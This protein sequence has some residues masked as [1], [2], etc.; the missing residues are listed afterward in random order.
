VC[1]ADLEEHI[2]QINDA[3]KV[4]SSW[5]FNAKVIGVW[6]DSTWNINTV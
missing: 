2:A 3:V 6:V 5:N 1:S 4:I